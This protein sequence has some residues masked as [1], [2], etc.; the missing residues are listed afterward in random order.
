MGYFGHILTHNVI[1]L[2]IMIGLGAALYWRFKV[3]IKTFS[4]LIFY[5]FT[6]VMI[7]KMLY[8]SDLTASILLQIVGFIIFFLLVLYGITEGVIRLRKL[9]KGMRS[10]MSNSVLFYNSANYAIPLN[11]LVF[12]GNTFT[13]SVQLIVMAFQSVLP[14]TYGI[15][16]VNAHKSTLKDTMRT[17]LGMPVIYAIPLAI[18][19]KELHVPIPQPIYEPITYIS[20][21]YVSL[22]LLTLGVQLG[23]MKWQIQRLWDVGLSC[24]LRLVAAPL[25]GFGIVWTMG[26]H[27][28]MAQALVLSCAVP[29]S[30]SSVLLSVEFDNEPEFA[31][32]VVFAS[33]LLS[34]FTVTVVIYLLQFI[35]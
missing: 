2:C 17:I 6:P 23:Q 28:L 16:A 7:F 4:K 13:M 18:V 21:G 31:G 12:A 8:E 22:A 1:P 10:A 33:T 25:I 27:G 30:L 24:V 11:Q 14:H 5:L 20:N 15:Y 32:Q 29:T 3:D 19:L 34:I 26:L 35:S 9:D